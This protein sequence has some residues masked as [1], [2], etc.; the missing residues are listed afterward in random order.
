MFY[1]T[2]FKLLQLMFNVMKMDIIPLKNA[3]SSDVKKLKV[4]IK[5]PLL[6]T[7]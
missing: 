1:F 2:I 3:T 6:G 7:V 5:N 4:S